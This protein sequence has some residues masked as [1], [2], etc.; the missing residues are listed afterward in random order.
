MRH[1]VETGGK[2]EFTAISETGNMKC[3]LPIVIGALS[4]SHRSEVFIYQTY[5]LSLTVSV[6]FLKD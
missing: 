3:P 1:K 2:F 5:Q 6:R 4:T